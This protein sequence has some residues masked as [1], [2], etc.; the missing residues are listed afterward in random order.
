[1]KKKWWRDGL[2]FECTQCGKCCRVEGYVW[3]NTADIAKLA[4]FLQ[5]TP[6]AFE[7]K[8]LRTV[9]RRRS[10]IEKPNF[11][12]IFWDGGCSVYPVRPPQ[13]K[14]YP[15]WHQNLESI[16][17]WQEVVEECPGSGTG[18]VYSGEEIEQLLRQKGETNKS[19]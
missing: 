10:L 14:T 19:Q 8:Y 3:V 12:C 9:G 6:P 4:G 7:K 11:E 2:P 5:M 16:E 1:M 18:S 17:T 13:C 15:F